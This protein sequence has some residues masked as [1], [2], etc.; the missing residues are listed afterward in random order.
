MNEEKLQWMPQKY[1]GLYKSTY[2]RYMPP[3]SKT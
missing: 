3:N 1:K 2:E